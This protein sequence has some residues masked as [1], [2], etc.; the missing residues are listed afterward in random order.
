MA[1]HFK[2]SSKTHLFSSEGVSMGRLKTGSTV[3]SP[4]QAT[5]AS[6]P[7]QKTGDLFS[8]KDEPE[9]PDLGNLGTDE[10]KKWYYSGD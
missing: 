4:R 2:T 8:G 1:R 3:L 6:S 10:D 9:T 5:A 7:Q